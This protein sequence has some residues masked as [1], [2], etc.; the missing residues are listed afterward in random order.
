MS[1]NDALTSFKVATSLMNAGAHD[2]SPS[3]STHT[4][5][6]VASNASSSAFHIKYALQKLKEGNVHEKS[7]LQR[8]N[9]QLH[10]YLENV[11]M[12]EALNKSLGQEVNR[13]K[14]QRQAQPAFT[15]KNELTGSLEQLRA[16]LEQEQQETVRNVLRI[17]DGERLAHLFDSR[18]GFYQG[19]AEATRA[20]L[21]A[22]QQYLN[23]VESE[24]EHLMR[25]AV[26]A[27]E[28]I[29]QEQDRQMSAEQEIE[30]Y[31]LELRDVR[32]QNK[33]IEYEIKTMLDMTAFYKH[34]INFQDSF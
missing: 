12:L 1:S 8:L 26:T 20:R 24:R 28:F 25:G 19:E 21:S 2:D 23:Q 5:A 34:G 14:A 31:R 7:E 27:Q 4:V 30:K 29:K 32:A 11:R 13:A 18:I 6:T 10:S 17:E 33:R 16:K 3:Y 22:L 15:E 9:Q